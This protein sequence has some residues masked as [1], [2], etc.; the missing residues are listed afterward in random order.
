V[1]AG[2]TRALARAISP[3]SRR[4]VYLLEWLLPFLRTHVLYG[5]WA[6]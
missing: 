5:L 2:D 6:A 1:L 4:V 3:V